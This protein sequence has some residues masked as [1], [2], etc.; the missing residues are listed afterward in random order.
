[1]QLVLTTRGSYLHVKEG[2]FEIRIPKEKTP[3]DGIQKDG[4]QKENIQI[5]PQKIRSI[6]VTKSMSLS[7][8]AIQLAVENNIDI[9]FVD[10]IGKPFGR[11]WHDRLGSTT[12]IRKQQLLLSISP[13]ALSIGISFVQKKCDNQIEFLQRQRK[14]KSR[15]SSEITA[16]IQTIEKT[17]EQ[18]DAIDGHIDNVRFQVMGIEGNCAKEYWKL[19]SS[20]IP[21]Q[22]AFEGRSRNPAKDGF[23][24]MLNYAYGVLYSE[25]ER[26]CIIA[27]ID[28]YIGF[29]HTDHYAKVSMVL[30]VIEGYRIFADETV[31][32]LFQD[33]MIQDD[34]WDVIPNGV[35]LNEKGKKCLLEA[36]QRNLDTHILYRGRN[37]MK[38]NTIQMELHR[39]ANSWMELDVQ[40]NQEGENQL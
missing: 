32:A 36:F 24:C 14:R 3:K 39:V 4:I 37:I 8:D 6:L 27:G 20:I 35:F 33:K 26:A 10:D 11:L 1:M 17:K 23:N 13:K 34:M 30:D 9:V 2:I 40:H 38:R 29:L 22:Y 12:R 15:M 7:S 31:I 28:P 16:M 21:K 5:A 25:V 19:I 18:L